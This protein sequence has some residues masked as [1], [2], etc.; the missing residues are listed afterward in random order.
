MIATKITI[1]INNQDFAQ[2]RKKRSIRTFES[3]KMIFL[4]RFCDFIGIKF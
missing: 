1:I 3:N 2:I 4:E